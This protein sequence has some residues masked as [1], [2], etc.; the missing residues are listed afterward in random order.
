MITSHLMIAGL[1]CDVLPTVSI[2]SHLRVTA[3]P[4]HTSDGIATNGC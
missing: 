2:I 1:N 3:S 4:T